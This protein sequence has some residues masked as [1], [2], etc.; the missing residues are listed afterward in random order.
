LSG[1]LDVQPPVVAEVVPPTGARVR[2]LTGIE[3]VFSENVTGVDASDLLINGAPTT[4]LSVIS[5]RDYAFAFAEPAVGTVSVSWAAD[6]AITDL[7]V[8]GNPFVRTNWNYTLDPTAPLADVILSEFLA[9]NAN[10]DRDNFASR[11]DWIELFNRSDTAADLDGWFL[12]DDSSKLTKWRLPAVTLPGRKFLVVWASGMDQLNPSAPLH[13]NFKLGT[14][15]EYLALVDPRTNVVSEFAPTYPPQRSDVSYGRDQTSPTLVGYYAT[16]TPGAANSSSGTGFAPEPVFSLPGGLY[17][18]ATLAVT[19]SAAAGAIRYTTDG[20]RPTTNSAIYAGPIAITQSTVIQARVFQDGL[21]PSA[22]IVQTYNLLGTGSVGF[23]SNLPLLIVNTAGRHVAADVRTAAFVTAIEPFRGRASLLTPPAFQGNCQVELRGQTSL[24][25]PKVPYNLELNDPNGNDLE[26]SLLGLPSES[27]WVLYNPY[28]DK[29]F[30]QNF[31]AYELHEKMG[32]YSPRCR[33]VE[34]FVDTSGGKLDYPGDYQGIYILVEKIKVDAHRVDLARLTPQQNAEPEISGGYIIK[35]DKDSPGDLSF[36]TQGGG[37]FSGQALKIHEPKPREITSAQLAWI[38]NYLNQFERALY[39]A[40]WLSA[41]G[42]NHY[43]HYL[44]VDSFVDQHWIVEFTKQIDGYRLSNY[45]SKDRGGKLRMEPIWDWNLSFGNADY[46]EGANTSGWYYRLIGENEHLW[47]RRLITGTTSPTTTSGDPDFNQKSVDRWSVLRT[48]VLSSTNVLARIDELAAYLNEAQVRDFAKWPRLGVYVWPNPP[49]YSA[50]TTYAGIIANMKNWVQGRYNWIDSQF[51]KPPEMSRNNSGVSPGFTL[52]LS[53]PAGVIYYTTDGTDP[54]APGG[55]LAPQ[56][57][58][59]TNGIVLETNSRVVARARNGNR[60]SGPRAA[61]YTVAIPPLLV[62][63]IMYAPARTSGQATNDAPR[64]EYVELVNAGTQPLDLRGFQFTGG[65]QFSFAT[66]AVTTL[67][68][69]A[70]VVVARDA[71]ALTT[72][73]GSLTNLAGPYEGS[74]ANEGEQLRLMGPMQE[75][76]QDFCYDPAWYPATDGL[77][78]ALVA[79]DEDPSRES[80]RL[81]GGWRVGTLGGTPG[82]EEP[83]ATPI[84]PILISEI[85]THTDPPL[86]GSIELHNPAAADVDI[87]GWYLSDDRLTPKYRIPAGTNIAAGGY[88][89]FTESDFN[90][91]PGV[92]PS[93]NLRA[94][95]DE[96]F[97]YSADA[98]GNLTGYVHSHRFGAALNG[99]SF[100]RHVTSTGEEHFVAQASRTLGQAN[101]LPRV[102]PVVISEIMYHPPDVF[103]NNAYWDNTEH[104]YVELLNLTNVAVSLFDP[105]VPTNT[106]RLRDAI[107]Y[108]FPT[109]QT[110]NVGERI[111]VIPFDPVADPAAAAAFRNQYGISAGVRLF[112]PYQGRLA[113]GN[114]SV[115][116]LQPDQ[117]RFYVTNLVTTAVLID[118]V[119]YEDQPPWPLGA[120]GLSFSLQRVVESAYGNDPTNWIAAAP[121]PGAALAPGVAPTI[122]DGPLS[123]TVAPGSDLTFRVEATGPDPLLYQWR[124]EG[125]NLPGAQGPSLTLTNVQ[126]GQSGAYQ[127]VVSTAARSTASAVAALQ[128]VEAPT[129]LTQ[130]ASIETWPVDAVMFSVIAVGNS[131]LRYQWR[132]NGSP[133]PGATG[134]ALRLTNVTA[135]Q[136]GVYDVVV[137]DATRA[138]PSEAASLRVLGT[139]VIVQQPLGITMPRGSDAAFSVEVTNTALLPISYEWRKDGVTVSRRTVAAR[140]DFL[141]LTPVQPD[142]AGAYSVEV[143]NRAS[144]V[145]GFMS[146]TV[147]LQVEELID[148]DGDGLPDAFESAHGL[149]LRNPADAQA[150]A[151]QDGASNLE[152]YRAGTDPQDP[153]SVLRVTE[154]EATGAIVIR[155]SCLASRTY[156]LLCRDMVGSGPWRPLASIP[157]TASTGTETRLVEV[158]DPQAPPTG[159]RY[160]RIVTPA[161]SGP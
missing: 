66:G 92:P 40:N 157:A 147:T 161:A 22:I 138:T 31:L 100:G 39:A 77:G 3:V 158:V 75:V 85:L 58:Q 34:V 16:P 89:V 150:D 131:S 148:S 17:L 20:S 82:R 149:D 102:G 140:M 71:V 88:L 61:T 8:P 55:A 122:R 160:Y 156:T 83:P 154:I 137:S 18:D 144:G 1:N 120:D 6:A 41:T 143:S 134:S 12:T 95:G 53:A 59:Y 72:R 49:I 23:S 136:A 60:W 80:W 98:S 2:A 124:F 135:L 94:S 119:E 151:D 42:T 114:D 43:S 54:R 28:S 116:L 64:F 87:G 132:R 7:A 73:Y 74:L 96:V 27:D 117:V 104:E 101:S 76:I 121:T 21:L 52:S 105:N 153:A 37:G 65:I 91:A 109:N 47:L 78:F 97:L 51:L 24:W 14:N 133:V 152:E 118:R 62:T 38:R 126:R 142:D 139:P 113:N 67:A 68:P 69:H 35:K 11:S 115:E 81:P 9:E 159:E 29:P 130:P 128:V 127:V 70:R 26:V 103:A 112:G 45:L 90:P 111:L 19:I 10:G 79:A 50:P 30:L 36:G 63:E 106:W 110:L 4:N 125:E 84:P 86:S 57:R 146:D 99:V 145:P 15:G 44:D 93:F 108:H 141:T 32:H 123:Q 56:A 13:A 155:F 107:S 46:L 25:F 5:P 48:N 33:F 129:I